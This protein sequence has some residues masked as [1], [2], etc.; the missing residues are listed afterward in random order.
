M[1]NKFAVLLGL[2]L[3]CPSFLCGQSNELSVAGIGNFN[4]IYWVGLQHGSEPIVGVNQS[5]L[6]KGASRSTAGGAVEY[7]HYWNT[8][9]ALGLLTEVNPSSID[10]YV[11]NSAGF[12]PYLQPDIRY[13]ID[14]LETK[15]SAQPTGCILLCKKV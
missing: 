15:F 3:L 9:N 14:V 7:R 2:L 12:T 8:S 4:P 1:L 13:D 11:P 5:F 10:L 6:Q